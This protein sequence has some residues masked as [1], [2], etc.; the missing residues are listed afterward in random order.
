MRPQNIVIH[1]AAPAEDNGAWWLEGRIAERAYLG[2]C[3]EY[4]V[5]PAGS[6]LRLRISTAPQ[7]VHDTGD[8]V[9][10]EI[11]PRRI[12]RIPSPD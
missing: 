4:V 6:D 7:T 2:D 8:A 12:A 5:R 3:W 11:D 10:L 9:W 1:R